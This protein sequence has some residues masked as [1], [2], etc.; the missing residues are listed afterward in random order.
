MAEKDLDLTKEICPGALIL[1]MSAIKTLDKGDLLTVRA[2]DKSTREAIPKL[3]ERAG[4]SLL[5]MT[6]E[7]ET[8]IFRIRK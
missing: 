4:F 5:E 7:G 2:T 8:I 1:T 3:C 6:D